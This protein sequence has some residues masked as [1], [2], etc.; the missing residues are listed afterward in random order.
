MALKK[1]DTILVHWEDKFATGIPLIDQQHRDLV[2]LTNELYEACLTGGDTITEVF[3]AAMRR[4]VEYVRHHFSVELQ[5]LER[6]QYP[7]L[8]E[9]RQ[10]HETLIKDILAAVLEHQDGKK[11]VPNNFVRTLRDWVFGHIG[12]SDRLY[13][14]YVAEQ[15]SKDLS[16]LRRIDLEGITETEDPADT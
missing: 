12:H 9:H 5:I 7:R 4:M 2:Q 8:E 13:A 1:S 15:R 14:A 3:S 16:F 10:E 6:I 11:F